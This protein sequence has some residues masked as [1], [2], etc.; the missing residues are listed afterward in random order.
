[1]DPSSIGLVSSLHLRLEIGSIFRDVRVFPVKFYFADMLVQFILVPAVIVNC[2][3]S[4]V[5]HSVSSF[6]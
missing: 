6:S 1:M 4:L 2:S 3:V 5:A